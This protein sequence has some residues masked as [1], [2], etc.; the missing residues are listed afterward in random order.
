MRVRLAAAFAAMM[1]VGAMIAVVL[2]H[3]P[4]FTVVG[5]LSTPLRPGMSAPLDLAI[6]NPHSY[7][8]TI[9]SVSVAVTAVKT[10]ENGKASHCAATNFT[11][12]EPTTITP[13]TVAPHSRVTLS[14]LHFAKAKWPQVRMLKT[15]VSQ[16]SCKHVSLTLSYSA[17]AAL[18]SHK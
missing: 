11:I 7:P 6:A 13:I 5:D 4:A 16:D 2:A 14:G 1:L 8:L 3:T 9:S 12:T 17:A 10:I 18:W 15:Q